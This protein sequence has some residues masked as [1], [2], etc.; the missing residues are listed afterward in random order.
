MRA[1]ILLHRLEEARQV[2]RL[3]M[4]NRLKTLLKSERGG[5]A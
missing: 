5:G 2:V 1:A 4:R 3:W